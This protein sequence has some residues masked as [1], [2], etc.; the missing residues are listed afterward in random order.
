VLGSVVGDVV[1]EGWVV[2]VGS[3]GS[4]VGSVVP[5]SGELV[6][7]PVVGVPV[8]SDGVPVSPGSVVGEGSSVGSSVGSGVG[9]VGTS[10]FAGTWTS[11]LPPAGVGSDG[12]TSGRT[13]RYSVKIATNSTD[14]IAVEV[15]ARP[16]WWG[17]ASQCHQEGWPAS[18][19]PPL[20]AVLTVGAAT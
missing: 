7:L 16:R 5:A 14:R 19:V 8:S 11:L 12:A 6:V 3:L 4:V 18:A 15:R 2:S 10:G 13:F 1:S 9:S 17:S 20:G